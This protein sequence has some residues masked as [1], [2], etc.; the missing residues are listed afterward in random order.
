MFDIEIRKLIKRDQKNIADYL[1]GKITKEKWFLIS[2]KISKVFLCLLKKN[3][4]PY[5]NKTSEFLYKSAI[6]LSLHLEKRDL[7]RVF[8]E[9][10]KN[11]NN[12]QVLNEHKIIFIDKIKVISG[13]KQI[14]G[15]QFKKTK[16][17]KVRFLP[18]IN[19]K[20]V[21]ERRKKLGLDV[22]E[23]YKKTIILK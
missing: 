4:F 3:N 11:S 19:R 18:I 1:Y 6:T 13:K 9:F 22:I 17:G 15:S 12:E 10:I 14:Y 21:N 2:Q 7:K 23:N 20:K 5:R 8:L 16:D